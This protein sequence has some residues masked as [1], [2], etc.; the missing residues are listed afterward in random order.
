MDYAHREILGCFVGSVLK[1][2]GRGEAVLGADCCTH[3][4][5]AACSERYHH[6]R[7]GDQ[8]RQRDRYLLPHARTR[9]HTC[10]VSVGVALLSLS[11]ALSLSFSLFL[12][13]AVLVGVALRDHRTLSPA[14][15]RPTPAVHEYIMAV[16]ILQAGIWAAALLSSSS[17]PLNRPPLSLCVPLYGVPA[18]YGDEALSFSLPPTPRTRIMGNSPR[19]R[20]LGHHAQRAAPVCVESA[21]LQVHLLTAQ[22]WPEDIVGSFYHRR[23]AGGTGRGA[24]GGG[25]G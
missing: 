6:H 19:H 15:T 8:Q 9:S 25:G 12:S 13:C 23:L 3:T 2:G 4:A 21:K 11:L 20:R 1:D 7:G 22:D 5:L 16:R 24:T 10:A 14:T 18:N 17:P